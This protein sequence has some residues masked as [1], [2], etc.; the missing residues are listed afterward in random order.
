MWNKVSVGQYQQIDI[1]LR[2]DLLPLDKELHIYSILF[3]RPVEW[4]EELPLSELVKY[5]QRTEFLKELPKDIL[6]ARVK[7]AQRRYQLTLNIES[8]TG[9]DF[10]DLTTYTKNKDEIIENM[11]KLLAIFM[12]P[13][14]PWYYFGKMNVPLKEREADAKRM[15]MSDAY[16]LT[17]FFC[18]VL[19]NLPTAMQDYLKKELDKLIKMV[20]KE[21][22][23]KDS[24]STG[25]GS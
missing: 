11:H 22:K 8:L 6:T 15:V 2:S 1:I 4:F 5:R 13:V 21:L 10:I 23:K 14:K 16:P 24:K 20:R 25:D 19:N 18:K 7:V 12:K 3:G 17:L 9:G